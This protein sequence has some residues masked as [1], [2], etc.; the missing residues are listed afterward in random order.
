MAKSGLTHIDVGP[1][2]TRTEWESEES[3]ALI[4]GTSFPGSPVERQLFYRND[5]HEWYIYTGSA[6]ASL[7]GAGGGLVVHDNAFHSPDYEEQGVAATQIETHRT[8]AVHVAD[9]PPDVHDNTKHTPT[10]EEE[11]YA[12][13]AIEAHRT[14]EVHVADQPPDLHDNAKHSPDFA[15]EVALAT[16]DAADTALHGVGASTVESASGAQAKV[17]THA[18]LA[19]A[20]HGVGAGTVGILNKD[21]KLI[22]ADGDTKI[23]VEEA[24]DEDTIRMDVAGVE[25]FKLSSIGVLTLA[26][27]SKGK[28]YRNGDWYIPTEAW[29]RVPL[30][31]ESY[32][33]QNEFDTTSKLGTADATEAN[34]LHDADG[35]FA[36]GDVGKW[37]YNSTDYTYTTVVAFVDDGELTLA[38]DIMADTEGYELYKSVFTAIEEGYYLVSGVVRCNWTLADKWYFAGIYKNGAPASTGG[39]QSAVG[40][41]IATNCISGVIVDVLY[42][43]ANDIV[44]LYVYHNEGDEAKFRGEISQTFLAVHKLS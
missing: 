37:V 23:Q 19:T 38:A 42:L 6:W 4:N 22:D 1:E 15:T 32:D 18:A 35:G 9:Q 24:A 34:K 3:H 41:G 43:A 2:L 16:H 17:D 33:N 20:V 26:K 25:A 12:D 14:T 11:G 39:W 21:T 36:A 40:D 7:Q 44:S 8:T 27:Q 31:A 13:V 29:I 5:L 10:F 28:A 30:N